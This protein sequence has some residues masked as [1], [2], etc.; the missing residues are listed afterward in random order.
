MVNKF[1]NNKFINNLLN[2]FSSITPV[3]INFWFF[4]LVAV[5]FLYSIYKFNLT[6]VEAFNLL[7]CL[8]IMII[9]INALA[10]KLIIKHFS[11]KL[12]Q[13][14]KNIEDLHDPDKM[15]LRLGVDV[16][17]ITIHK[18]LVPL[19]DDG[20]DG[21]LLPKLAALRQVLTDELGFILPCVRIMDDARLKNNEYAL[22]VRNIFADKGIVYPDRVM[23]SKSEWDK[24]NTSMPE[25]RIEDI[26]PIDKTD[27]Y[28]FKETDIEE[29]KDIQK[30]QPEDVILKHLRKISIEHV[31]EIMSHKDVRKLIALVKTQNPELTENLV[32]NLLSLADIKNI[33]TNLIREEIS[34]RDIVYIFENLNDFARFTKDANILSEKLRYAM[35]RQ[36]CQKYIINNKI[37]A[38]SFSQDLEKEAENLIS[39]ASLGENVDF[40]DI[41]NIINTSLKNTNLDEGILPI[42]LVSSKIRLYLYKHLVDFIPSVQVVAYD[43]LSHK[44]QVE[45]LTELSY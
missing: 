10:N 13:L 4:C 43:E 23:V 33:L 15:P 11:R 34:I 38:L 2:Y 40:R 39:K 16:L 8:I 27:V 45:V 32:P 1:L 17:L 9:L 28:W 7:L 3:F 31:S 21:K 14:K 20:Q 44:T 41:A 29:I 6:T 37:Y 35:R 42:I 5:I 22:R 30:I 12:K 26:N 25:D 19:A 18:Q 36:I 24:L